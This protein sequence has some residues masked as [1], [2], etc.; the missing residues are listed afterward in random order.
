MTFYKGCIKFDD[1]REFEDLWVNKDDALGYYSWS[2]NYPGCV[3]AELFEMNPDA[4][5]FKYEGKCIYEYD[6]NGKYYYD[7]A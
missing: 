3:R 6:V 5:N 4:N 2:P 7:I 1:G